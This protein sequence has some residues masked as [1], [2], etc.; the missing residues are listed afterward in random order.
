MPT[1]VAKRPGGVSWQNLFY[2]APVGAPFALALAGFLGRYAE[3]VRDLE[4]DERND[5]GRGLGAAVALG[6]VGTVGEAAL[7]HFRGAYHN[8]AMALPVTLPPISAA[9]LAA[10]ALDPTPARQGRAGFWLK[11]TAAL[12]FIGVGFHMFGV[13]RN[14]GGWRNW[15]QNVLNGPPLPSPPSF[16]GLAL[17]G[18]AALKLMGKPR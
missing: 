12:G 13:A 6:L 1:T 5:A 14:M 8:P 4:E 7:L 18:L 11:A 17:A 9:L 15:S 10:A 16:T 2:G 3:T